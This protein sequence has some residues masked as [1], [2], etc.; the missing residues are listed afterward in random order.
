MQF[1][2]S[3][4][5]TPSQDESVAQDKLIQDLRTLTL[6]KCL[7]KDSLLIT[8]CKG[9]F[10][11]NSASSC[12]AV[13]EA[14]ILSCLVLLLSDATRITLSPTELDNP[15]RDTSHTIISMPFPMLGAIP[16]LALGKNRCWDES[17]S[18]EL[19]CVI[20]RSGLCQKEISR[21]VPTPITAAVPTARDLSIVITLCGLQSPGDGSA[22]TSVLE[23]KM[24]SG[25]LLPLLTLSKDTTLSLLLCPLNHALFI[26]KH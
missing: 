7:T 3:Q 25:K 16:S 15:G 19:Q 26:S 5:Q 13:L 10:G 18:V 14:G 9:A 12:C 21:T 20:R 8:P 4:A 24:D 23:S 1:S 17:H 11:D 22:L 2:V 6:Q